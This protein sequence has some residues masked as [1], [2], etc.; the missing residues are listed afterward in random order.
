MRTSDARPTVLAPVNGDAGNL[1]NILVIKLSAL[2]D[3][4]LC[5]AAFAAIRAHHASAK[6][7]LLTTKPFVTLAEKSGWFNE[8]MV[9]MRPGALNIGGWAKLRTQLRAGNFTHVYDLQ[10][11]DRS[12]FYSHLFFPGPSPDWTGKID[13]PAWEKLHAWDMRREQL[14]LAGILET[15]LP[16]VAWLDADI[17]KYNL[18]QKFVLVCAGAAPSRPRKR[19]TAAGYAEVCRHL[20][21]QNITPVLIGADAEMAIHAAI[22]KAAPGV[23]DLTN[24]TTLFDIAAL[25]RHAIGAIG[26]DT[27]PMHLIAAAGCPTLSLFSND[28]L[29]S[30]S[31]PIGKHTAFLQRDLLDDLTAE[32]VIRVILL[33]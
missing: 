1:G 8:I 24:Q 23:M 29:P 26:N 2:G 20:L 17:S 12:S 7:T 3:F 33:R 15:P 4:I 13:D 18:P 22:K 28:S 11:N 30:H 6:I 14:R 10:T 31:R 5:F 9:D 25:A 19:W 27:G 32:E 21:A 16:D